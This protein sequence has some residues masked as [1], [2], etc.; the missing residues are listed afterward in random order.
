MIT[1]VLRNNSRQLIFT[2]NLKQNSNSR[3]IDII[4]V[5]EHLPTAAAILDF[6]QA[7]NYHFPK[8]HADGYPLNNKLFPT[9]RHF[10]YFFMYLGFGK[11][12]LGKNN[13]AVANAIFVPEPR[14]V[15]IVTAVFVDN[16]F[17]VLQY[18]IGASAYSHTH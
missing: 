17:L 16:G 1:H 10:L 3:D 14:H 15:K 13:A 11:A 7:V 18:L 9:A 6:D 5:A 4:Y 12:A 2:K 8:I